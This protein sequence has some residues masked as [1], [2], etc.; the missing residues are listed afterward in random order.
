MVLPYFP[1]LQSGTLCYFPT[2]QI[3]ISLSGKFVYFLDYNMLL[4]HQYLV[5]ER[6]L[7]ARLHELPSGPHSHTIAILKVLVALTATILRY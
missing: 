3:G 1:T 5:K 6:R 7:E 4:L 2:L